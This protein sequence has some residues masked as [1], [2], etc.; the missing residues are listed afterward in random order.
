MPS[1]D[2][3]LSESIVIP[4]KELTCTMPN[5]DNN[6]ENTFCDSIVY[7]KKHKVDQTR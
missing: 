1:T 5:T 3:T 7:I 4:L 2:D 6:T